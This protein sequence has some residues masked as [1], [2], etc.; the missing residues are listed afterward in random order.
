MAHLK[1]PLVLVLT[2]CAGSLIASAC[3]RSDPED[4]LLDSPLDGGLGGGGF[5]AEGGFGAGEPLRPYLCCTL[6]GAEQ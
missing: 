6:E 2:L 3:G 5:G 4:F 1:R